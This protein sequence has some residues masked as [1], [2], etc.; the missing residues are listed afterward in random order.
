MF[1]HPCRPHFSE[2]E[3]MYISMF[4]SHPTW[5]KLYIIWDELWNVQNLGFWDHPIDSDRISISWINLYHATPD[6]LWPMTWWRY[7]ETYLISWSSRIL[8]Q[9]ICFIPMRTR[10]YQLS[11]R[12]GIRYKEELHCHLH[13]GMTLSLLFIGIITIYQGFI[14]LFTCGRGHRKVDLFFFLCSTLFFETY[15]PLSCCWW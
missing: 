7:D 9:N 2:T 11:W 6:L 5:C 15:W 12:A 8:N 10:T 13:T 4:I 1:T 3:G 14:L